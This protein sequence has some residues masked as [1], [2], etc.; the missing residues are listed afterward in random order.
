MLKLSELLAIIYKRTKIYY[1]KKLY[2]EVSILGFKYR[3][4]IKEYKKYID[5]V[6]QL[7]KKELEKLS[8]TE[9]NKK[10]NYVWTM[11]LQEDVPEIIQMCIES[12]KEQYKNVIIISEKNLSSY[13]NVPDYILYKYK[14]GKI[15]PPHFS[16]YI[17]CCLLDKYG[18]L[19]IDASCFMLNKVP[20]FIIKQ[21]FF[22]LYSKKRTTISNFFIYSK[23]N[24]YI[25]KTMRIFLEIYWKNVDIACGYFFFHSAF[26]LFIQKDKLFNDLYH[27]MVPYSSEIIKYLAVNT[28]YDFDTDLWNYLKTA[29]FMYKINRKNEKAMSNPN[30]FYQYLLTQYQSKKLKIETK[31]ESGVVVDL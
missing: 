24:N 19:W 27:K 13:V 26:N 16:D 6:P 20:K 15:T 3:K 8:S 11:W 31:K 1:D 4:R 2:N 30:G 5:K 7:V 12:I 9:I 10:S 17:R 21:D 29:S 28:D 22:I 23:T 14:K 18:G 25:I